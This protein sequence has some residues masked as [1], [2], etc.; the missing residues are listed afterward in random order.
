MAKK[1]KPTKKKVAKKKTKKPTKKKV[2][3]TPSKVNK[4]TEGFLKF[5]PGL[6]EDTKKI[7]LLQKMFKVSEMVPVINS[8]AEEL[9]EET[10]ETYFYTEAKE[11][12][13]KYQEAFQKVGIMF[14][15]VGMREYNDGRFYRAT[16]RYAIYDIETGYCI[17]VVAS[18]LGCNGGWA[19]NTCQT[20]ARKQALLNTFGCS[21][22]QPTSA[23]GEVRKMTKQFHVDKIIEIT[24]GDKSD[25]PLAEVKKMLACNEA[26]IPYSDGKDPF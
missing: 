24:G 18:G 14:M 16:I 9:D 11:V 5:L 7:M 2:K 12:F 8:T 22:G 17:K 26:G 20:V 10:N 15:P 3:K 6:D 19:L 25:D 1:K 4:A 21:Y 13:A 23:A